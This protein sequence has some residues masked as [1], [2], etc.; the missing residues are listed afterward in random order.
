V[1]LLVLYSVCSRNR[2]GMT[3]RRD[4]DY[5]LEGRDG[6]GGGVRPMADDTARGQYKMTDGIEQALAREKSDA[7]FGAFTVLA[8]SHKTRED[9]LVVPMPDSFQ[10]I[11]HAARCD[12]S[13]FKFRK[14]D[15]FSDFSESNWKFGIIFYKALKRRHT[16][17]LPARVLEY[18]FSLSTRRAPATRRDPPAERSYRT[19]HH[20]SPTSS[21]T[22]FGISRTSA[23]K[24]IRAAARDVMSRR[25]SSQAQ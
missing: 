5:D 7:R 11:Q 2:K 22:Y 1:R 20:P 25:W 24:T 15:W 23:D 17:Q 4:Q 21:I 16:G 13:G 8:T 18:S 10:S 9:L 19:N 12:P 14:P 6:D 3:K